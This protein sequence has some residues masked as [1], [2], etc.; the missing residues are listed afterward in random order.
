M[1]ATNIYHLHQQ[2][3]K[4]EIPFDPILEYFKPTIKG[5]A[6][7]YARVKAYKQKTGY[8]Y[9]DWLSHGY[10]ACLES[11]KSYNADHESKK[12]LDSYVFGRL[13]IEFNGILDR[14]KYQKYDDSE[15]I[16]VPLDKPLKGDEKKR[17]IGE[18]IFIPNEHDMDTIKF[19]EIDSLCDFISLND[20]VVASTLK[21]IARGQTVS[22]S[23]RQQG[24]RVG[25][26]DARM[27][28]HRL[29]LEKEG[30]TWKHCT[31]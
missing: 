28:R 13:L 3:L 23:A 24:I 21:M 12:S 4:G 8:D 9:D 27:K 10:F 30:I 29:K 7:K 31:Y 18:L 11:C 2:W 15:F 1:E 14:K 6:Y 19:I 22:D 16:K 17:T 26:L 5:L 25:T 20:E